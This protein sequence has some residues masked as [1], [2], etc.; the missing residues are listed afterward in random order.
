[1]LKQ[2]QEAGRDLY[3]KLVNAH[4]YFGKLGTALENAVGNYN[5]FVG[6]VEG[7]GG[8]FFHARKLGNLVHS[9]DEIEQFEALPAEPRLL[10]AEDWVPAP[11]FSL[12]A[13]ADDQENSKAYPE[14][15]TP[16]LF[17]VL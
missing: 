4:E 17:P 9:D 10:T 8:A 12:A 15:G 5:R 6:A 14:S 11:E 1:M 7:R 13:G 2:I 16:N 3:N